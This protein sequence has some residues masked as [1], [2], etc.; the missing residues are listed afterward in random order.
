MTKALFMTNGL[1]LE[2]WPSFIETN[3][4]NKHVYTGNFYVYIDTFC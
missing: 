4:Q 1:R 3:W 2:D